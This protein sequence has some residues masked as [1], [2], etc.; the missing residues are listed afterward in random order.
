MQKSEQ[1]RK[2]EQ[3]QQAQEKKIERL[4]RKL[5]AF[6]YEN[7]QTV[8]QMQADKWLEPERLE[9]LEEIRRKRAAEEENQPVQMSMADYIEM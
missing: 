4:E 9:E 5:I 8:D 7:L 6:G 1:T 2:K 3:R